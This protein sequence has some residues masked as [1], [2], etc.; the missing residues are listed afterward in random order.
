MGEDKEEIHSRFSLFDIKNFFS[1]KKFKYIIII[2][3]SIVVCLIFLSSYNVFDKK[4][5]NI[6]NISTESSSWKEYCE[7]QEHR[8][9]YVLESIKGISNVKVFVMVDASPTITYLENSTKTN[10]SSNESFQ[11]TA[12]EVKNGTITM[13]VV[14]VETLPK[15]IGVLVVAGGASSVKL[16]NTLANVVSNILKVSLANVEVLEGK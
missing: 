15:I 1:N 2:I 13:P 6:Q 4:Q 16:K 9:E 7:S 12:V 14:V 8:L 5:T 3:L 11:T 10:S